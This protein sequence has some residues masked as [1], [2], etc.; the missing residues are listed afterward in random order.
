MK[1]ISSF[2]KNRRDVKFVVTI[3]NKY[4]VSY[5]FIKILIFQNTSIST[6][7]PYE[8]EIKS[9]KEVPLL[10]RSRNLPLLTLFVETRESKVR[11]R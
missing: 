8:W 9:T 7:F 10:L 3:L 5:S 4:T 6:V 11:E 2:I 1:K